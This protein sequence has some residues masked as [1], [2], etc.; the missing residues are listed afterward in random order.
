MNK[1]KKLILILVL[2]IVPHNLISQ[3]NI[4]DCCSYYSLKYQ[5]NYEEIFNPSSIKS[6]GIKQVMVYTNPKTSSDSSETTKYREIKFE[7][8]RNGFV[9]SKTWY[10]RKGKPHSTYDFKRNKAGK[11]YQQTFNYID[12]LEQKSSP[13]GQEITDF[14]YDNKN[15]LVKIKERSSSGEILADNKSTYS[16]IK[17]DDKNRIVRRERY[18][19]WS[20]DDKTQLSITDFTF[21]DE[22]FSATYKSIWDGGQTISGEKKYN[23]NWQQTMGKSFNDA[24]KSIAFEE[25]YEYDSNNKLIKYQTISGQGAGSECPDGGSYIDNYEYD[26]NGFLTKINHTFNENV[27]EMTFEYRKTSSR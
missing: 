6:S 4:C 5:Q 21:S 12:S 27:C 20:Y 17:Y 8:D 15:R 22:S 26:S 24:L 16:I 25:Y 7:F 18:I 2:V 13:F 23:Q 14:S 11:I 3:D 10:N 1:I 9:I 19:Y